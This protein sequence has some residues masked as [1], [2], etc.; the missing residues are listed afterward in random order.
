MQMKSRQFGV[1][2]LFLAC[3][4]STPLYAE[5]ACS[6]CLQ[7]TLTKFNDCLASA[8]TE[9]E[10]TTCNMQANKDNV[11]CQQIDT[12]KKPTAPG[13]NLITPASSGVPA[14]AVAPAPAEK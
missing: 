2:F 6:E 8:K 1:L 5:D 13:K 3:S 7:K 12:C 4:L 11:S 10:K 14:S 9:A